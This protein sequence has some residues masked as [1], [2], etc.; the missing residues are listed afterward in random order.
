MMFDG[1]RACHAGG[2]ADSNAVEPECRLASQTG[3]YHTWA[4]KPIYKGFWHMCPRQ[5]ADL[6][7]VDARG[8]ASAD[9]FQLG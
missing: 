3:W 1:L 7:L 9:Y 2:L 6:V 8:K 5:Q 4:L